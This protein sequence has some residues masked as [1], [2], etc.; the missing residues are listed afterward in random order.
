MNKIVTTIVIATILLSSRS[1]FASIFVDYIVDTDTATTGNQGQ[2]V[3]RDLDLVDVER[4]E[5]GGGIEV[6]GK[7]IKNTITDSNTTTDAIDLFTITNTSPS[8][9][10][11]VLKED[12]LTLRGN[13]TSEFE[14]L[15]KD[16]EIEFINQKTPSTDYS[17]LIF[18]GA[19]GN[20]FKIST[21]KAST[22]FPFFEFGDSAG[23]N[24]KI[25]FGKDANSQSRIVFPG[26]KFERAKLVITNNAM[27]EA[28]ELNFDS[29][30]SLSYE[31]SGDNGSVVTVNKLTFA[32]GNS[33]K[34]DNEMC[35]KNSSSVLGFYASN[36]STLA[37]IELTG[38]AKRTI[39]P[40]ADADFINASW[41][42]S[43]GVMIPDTGIF[44]LALIDDFCTSNADCSDIW[45]YSQLADHD[46]YAP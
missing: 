43:N 4:V 37:N 27:L 38:F 10:P 19:T 39:D 14:L 33:L 17:S 35:L 7:V 24:K 36:C 32:T 2:F 3:I 20:Y 1:V 46:P 18:R 15:P 25:I 5:A 34:I 44:Q 21:P 30:S 9:F 28:A 29:N 41:A 26:L 6:A 42:K 16:N 8:F 13:T 22:H 45:K 31:G 12:R 11:F 40:S 23:A